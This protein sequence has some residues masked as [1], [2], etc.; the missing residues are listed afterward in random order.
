MKQWRVD[1]ADKQLRLSYDLSPESQVLDLGDFEGQWA[2][3]IFAKYLCAVAVFEP[4]KDYAERIRNRFAKNNKISVFQYGL[5]ASNRK[6]HIH[7]AADGSSLFRNTGQSEEIVI[8][9]VRDWIEQRGI[10]QIDLMKVNIEGGEYELLDRLID[11]H[12][13][14]LFSNIQVQFHPIAPTSALAVQ[15]LR[16]ELMKTH[17]PTYQ[18]DFVWENWTRR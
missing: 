2:S 6:T 13:V 4:V 12:L 14:E 16:I 7:L 8:V 15:R 17:R 18:Y 10:P 5:G 3:D 11:T 1:D 9:D